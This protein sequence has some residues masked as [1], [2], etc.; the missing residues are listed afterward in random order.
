VTADQAVELPPLPDPRE[1]EQDDDVDEDDDSD[2][3][4]DDGYLEEA[5]PKLPH[6]PVRYFFSNLVVRVGQS[7]ADAQG[8][9]LQAGTTFKLMRS[10]H[11][12]DGGFVLIPLAGPVRSIRLESGDHAAIIENADNA[13]L[14][15]VPSTGCL[16]ELCYWIGKE[17]TK[18]EDDVDEDEDD[19][20]DKIDRI[21]T[22]RGDVQ[23]CRDWLEDRVGEPPKPGSTALAARIFGRNH[24]GAAWTKLLFAAMAVTSAG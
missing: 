14:Q 23:A 19:F 3:Q 21:D 10:N 17:L 8:N 18:A 22:L 24:R 11:D 20:E 7:F 16:A 5:P 9:Q 12:D 13:W 6:L 1:E 15:P 2:E 4:D